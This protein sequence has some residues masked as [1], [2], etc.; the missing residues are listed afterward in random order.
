M[1]EYYTYL[2][3]VDGTVWNR[4]GREIKQSLNHKGYP[5]VSLRVNGKP[6]TKTVH[7]IVAE[8]YLPNPNSLTDVDH[9]D[10]VKTN[11]HV[12]NLRWLS[13]GDN[14][15]HS[16]NLGNRSARGEGNARCV[17]SEEEATQICSLLQG[18]KT[19]A[20]LRDVGYP[21]QIVRAIKRRQT[22]KHVSDSFIF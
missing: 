5:H 7:R 3:G 1:K 14:I 12:S 8:L 20:Q 16:Y 22:W 15:K 9:I 6:H 21:Y 19:A 18:G 11:N 13:H 2:V 10:G 4:W 17:I